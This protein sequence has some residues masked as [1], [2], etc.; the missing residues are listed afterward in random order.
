MFNNPP[1]HILATKSARAKL[2]DVAVEN[3]KAFLS[4]KS[5][6]VVNK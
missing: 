2:M 6:N 3:L 1:P 4:G 5:A